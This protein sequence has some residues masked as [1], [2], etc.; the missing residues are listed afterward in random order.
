MEA[1]KTKRKF[2][3]MSS[4][5]FPLTVIL[6]ET[7]WVYP[8][9]LWIGN[10]P[11]FCEARPVLHLPG[12][13]LPLAAALLLTRFA[14]RQTAWS[15]RLMRSV[16]IG[17]GALVILIVLWFEYP[18]PEGISWFRYAGSLFGNIFVETGT[19]IVALITLIYLWW[20]GIRLG[21]TVTS[22]A[23][24][25][26]SFT[27]GMVLLI[28]LLVIWQMTASVLNISPPDAS[29]GWNI[30]GFFFFGLLAI[31]VC[32]LY[33]IRQSMGKE[34]G[35]MT[36]LKRWLPIMVGVIGG[37]A[38]VSLALAALFSPEFFAAV[39]RV[40]GK[41]RDFFFMVGDYLMVP[42]NYIFEAIFQALRWIINLLR[43]LN[44][45]QEEM[46]G[47]FGEMEWEEV[48]TGEFPQIAAEVIKWVVII[49]IVVAVIFFLAR[50]VKRF[51]LKKEDEDIEE[52]NESLFSSDGLRKDLAGMLGNMK[53][54]FTIRR[55]R[56]RRDKLYEDDL[57]GNLDV[58]EIYRRLL[59]EAERAGIPRK[60]HET[61]VEYARRVA[62]LVPESREY[63]DGI[64]EAYLPVRYGGKQERTV[65]ETN[66][67]WQSLRLIFRRL[68]GEEPPVV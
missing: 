34:E 17:A 41:V 22:P 47:G 64:N 48:V 16:V 66:S 11:L 9:L 6:M 3:W 28:I 63:L 46:E 37:V 38:V 25:Y 60:P 54:R 50:A 40:F 20:R 31:A 27:T 33:T 1:E 30:I 26:R 23:S 51:L 52:I 43:R 67:L 15:L 61:P 58:R 10:W 59:W 2:D 29:L 57:S 12:I 53:N 42:L 32:H 36:S 24:I 55:K 45:A 4:L 44:P 13:I 5:F 39:G 68:R 21:S 18:A 49:G 14:G 8:W 62:H 56:D 7:F 35:G 19:I 65:K